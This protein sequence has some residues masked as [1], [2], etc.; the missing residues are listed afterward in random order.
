MWKSLTHS[1]TTRRACAKTWILPKRPPQW[2]LKSQSIGQLAEAGNKWGQQPDFRECGE[3]TRSRG[4]QLTRQRWNQA[5][6]PQVHQPQ[7]SA[8]M[9][10]GHPGTWRTWDGHFSGTRGQD[11]ALNLSFQDPFLPTTRGCVKPSL[12]TPTKLYQRSAGRRVEIRKRY[13]M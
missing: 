11:N 7:M 8:S 3:L 1:H 12:Q 5:N 6:R 9:P 4:T 10:A 2:T 13:N